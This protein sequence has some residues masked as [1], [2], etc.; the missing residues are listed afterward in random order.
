MNIIVD[1][2]K[3]RKVVKVEVGSCGCSLV[4]EIFLGRGVRIIIVGSWGS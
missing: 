1:I 4:E 3:R 2:I